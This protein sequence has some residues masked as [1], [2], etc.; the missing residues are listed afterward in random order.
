MVYNTQAESVLPTNYDW[1][2]RSPQVTTNIDGPLWAKLR[3]FIRKMSSQAPPAKQYAKQ[4]SKSTC[5]LKII[6]QH[7]KHFRLNL[8]FPGSIGTHP[9]VG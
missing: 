3:I 6:L 9:P 2:A 4:A 1:V 5:V 8:P 7:Q